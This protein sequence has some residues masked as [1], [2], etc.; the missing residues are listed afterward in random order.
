MQIVQTESQAREGRKKA[1]LVSHISSSKVV[2]VKSF[3]IGINYHDLPK[4]F[5]V[6]KTQ[7]SYKEIFGSHFD[8]QRMASFLSGK[9]TMF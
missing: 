5:I 4:E 1:L 6:D 7:K 9:Q 3:K 8:V 2:V